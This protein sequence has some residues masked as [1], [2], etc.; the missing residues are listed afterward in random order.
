MRS[1]V[2]LVP[3]VEDLAVE[4]AEAVRILCEEVRVLAEILFKEGPI[5]EGPS[6]HVYDMIVKGFV[7]VVLAAVTKMFEYC[8]VIA[9][10]SLQLDGIDLGSEGF[11]VKKSYGFA[12]HRKGVGGGSVSASFNFPS[13]RRKI[14]IS[15]F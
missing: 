11:E 8:P 15:G 3:E 10:V 2:K 6:K 13:E 1:D 12:T 9:L 5:R 7:G 4:L 14:L